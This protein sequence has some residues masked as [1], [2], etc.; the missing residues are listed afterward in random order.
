MPTNPPLPP[1]EPRNPDRLPIAASPPR[2]KL[3]RRAS[4]IGTVIALL[5]AAGL[6]W[7]AWDLT[8]PAQPATAGGAPGA[9]GARAG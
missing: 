6:A 4:L 5:V 8:R 2:R 9:A 7:L 1:G 3:S